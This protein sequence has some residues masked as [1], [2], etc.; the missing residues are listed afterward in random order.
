MPGF[1][2]SNRKIDVALINRFP[3]R[4]VSQSLAKPG[5]TAARNTL[6]KFMQDK[7][8]S[9]TAEAI[10]ILEGFLLNKHTLFQKYHAT[11][12]DTLMIQMYQEKGDEFFSEFR[13]GFSGAYY[14]KSQDKWLVFTNHTGDQPV[15][16][17]TIPG[18][19]CAGSQ[20]NYLVDACRAIHLPLTVSESAI[21]QMLTFAFMVDDSTYANEIHRLRGGTYLLCRGG[22]VA[23]NTY[24]TFKKDPDRFSGCTEAQ[25]IDEI[26]RGF[27]A[28][29]KLEYDKDLEYGCGHL[30]DI[31]GG[32]DSR[33]TTWV[34]YEMGYNPIHLLTYCKANYADEIIAKEIA[35]Y[36]RAPLLVKPL[37][38]AAFLYDIDDIT[39]LNNGLSLYSGISGGYRMLQ[40]L[41]MSSWGIEHTGMSGD[42]IVGS[43]YQTLQASPQ[44][45]P[46]GR[47]SERLAHRLPDSLTAYRNQFDDPELYLWYTRCFQ[48]AANTYPIRKNFLEVSSPFMDVEFMQLCMDI[49]AEYRMHHRIYKKWIIAKYPQAA[50]FKW[51][52]TNAKITESK[53]VGQ[54]RRIVTKGPKKLLRMMGFGSA[55]SSSMVPID[56]FIARDQ[57]IKAHLDGYFTDS[58]SNL[59]VSLSDQLLADMQNLYQT[60]NGCE[61]TMVLTVLASMKLYFGNNL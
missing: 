3:D 21:Y 13:G 10:T 37:D 55:L 25:L 12:V 54:I 4:C 27:R 44:Q 45:F 1:F 32:L 14:D 40:S 23:V 8:L 50:A 30:T 26:D 24:F 35:A 9:E 39:F 46:T 61:K 19:F 58:L 28:A 57:K 20:V 11:T 38:D 42:V 48:G 5:L 17:A 60:G 51:E 43:W 7:A 33:M 53:L 29:V 31:S 2:A 52:A 59:P 22:Q 36:W 56:Y 16:Y 34:P 47:Y 41:N 18:G 6:N 15:F 49:P